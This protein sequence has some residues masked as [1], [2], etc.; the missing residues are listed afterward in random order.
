MLGR[1]SAPASG[2]VCAE[3]ENP[4]TLAYSQGEKHKTPLKV[5]LAILFYSAEARRKQGK[6][7]EALP[8]LLRS[9]INS[10]ADGRKLDEAVKLPTSH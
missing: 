1:C 9:I 8:L 6:I 2:T 7:L 5:L 10:H 3:A 4:L